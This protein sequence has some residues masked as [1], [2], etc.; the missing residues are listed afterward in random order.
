[1]RDALS[2]GWT[3]DNDLLVPGQTLDQS[4]KNDM[5]MRISESSMPIRHTWGARTWWAFIVVFFSYILSTGDGNG[6]NPIEVDLKIYYLTWKIAP[7]RRA[8]CT[9]APATDS[10]ARKRGRLVDLQ[11]CSGLMCDN[12]QTL[13]YW[14]RFRKFVPI[15]SH[16]TL[17]PLGQY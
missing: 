8:P 12:R 1:M 16:V 2:V 10:T 14:Q 13:P 5:S 9:P 15:F 4:E 6:K 3:G 7:W 17:C 11:P